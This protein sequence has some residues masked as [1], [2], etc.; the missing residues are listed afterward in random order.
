MSQKALKATAIGPWYWR[1]LLHQPHQKRFGSQSVLLGIFWWKGGRE[2]SLV[3]HLSAPKHRSCSWYM[4]MDH[5][6][7]VTIYVL[8]FFKNLPIPGRH[9]HETVKDT[10]AHF[11]VKSVRNMLSK[12]CAICDPRKLSPQDTR[13]DQAPAVVAADLADLR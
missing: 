9:W 1:I 10:C 8:I 11:H 3:S 5:E 4:L 12:A 7:F 13:S 6:K 2:R